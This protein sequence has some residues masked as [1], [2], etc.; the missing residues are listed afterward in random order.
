M[1][2]K[3]F[4]D[5]KIRLNAVLKDIFNEVFEKEYVAGIYTKY[6][7]IVIGLNEVFPRYIIK[8]VW[9]FIMKHRD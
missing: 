7:S 1:M 6:R 8:K 2:K 3:W 4:E 9:I 5:T